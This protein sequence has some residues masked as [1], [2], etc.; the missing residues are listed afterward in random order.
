MKKNKTLKFYLP[1]FFL[2]FLLLLTTYKTTKSQDLEHYLNQQHPAKV[3]PSETV[4]C[5]FD[6]FLDKLL[7]T[8][9]KLRE[10]Q[11][12]ME[13]IY[14]QFRSNKS[15][16]EDKELE[17]KNATTL[18][19][20]YTLPIVV[21][22]IHDN[23]VENISDDQVIQ[24]IAD[25]NEAF[26]NTS[27][28]DSTI[29]VDTKI[30]FCLAMQD[31]DGNA[32]TGITRTESVLTYNVNYNSSA[33]DIALKDLSRWD[34]LKYINIW[35]VGSIAGNVAGYSTL[36]SSVGNDNDG[37]VNEAQYFGTSKSNSTIHT[38]EIGHYLGL[39]HTF[40]G[41]CTNN[42][43]LADGDKVCDTPPDQSTAA[44]P[45]NATVNSCITDED[46]PSVNNPFRPVSLGGIGDQNDL[47]KNYMDYAF[48]CGFM[49]TQGQADRMVFF[50]NNVRME[51]LGAPSCS[52]PCML[53]VAASFTTPST[54]VNQGQT[55]NFTNTTI[56]GTI[57]E[58]S[59]Y[60]TPFST[61]TN[62]SYLFTAQGIFTITL[63]A[64]NAEPGCGDSF[65]MQIEVTC[66]N[67]PC[68]EICNNSIDDDN[69]GLADCLD[70]DCDCDDLC[71][72][73]GE[74]DNWFFGSNAA[75]SF[76]GGGV[77]I[78]IANSSLTASEGVASISDPDGNLL[79]YTN[80]RTA[81]NA[82]NSL[83]S[84]GTGLSGS[85]IS[86]QSSIIVPLPESDSL[87]YI[88]TVPDWIGN[89]AGLRYTV[90]DMSLNSGLGGVIATQKNISVDLNVAERVTAALHENCRDI[91]IVS[92]QRLN[93][94]FIAY[95]LTPSGVST[96]PV[97]SSVGAVTN[98]GNRYGALKLSHDGKQIS[99]TLG[100]SQSSVTVALYD[101]DYATGVVS[102]EQI[103]ADNGLISNAYSSEFSSD[104]SK[105]YVCSYNGSFV[106][107]FDLS[108]ATWPEVLASQTN[109]AGSASGIK[110]CIQI[111]PDNKI[112]VAKNN[113][114]NMDVINFP[115][116]VGVNCG[117]SANIVNLNGN[118]ARIGLPNF[119]PFYF[120]G[121][122]SLSGVDSICLG[123]PTTFTVT[124]KDCES[125]IYSWELSGN[126][127]IIDS[128]D[129]SITVI[130]ST[131]PET[132]LI[133]VHK[134]TLC[135]IESD[136]SA[137]V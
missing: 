51:L 50:L 97:T 93:N 9:A 45:C 110:G 88:F 10:G 125:A 74:A 135:G 57:Y 38:H 102:N 134:E 67:P 103:I 68:I 71:K 100:G 106:Y 92:H 137:L 82:N 49:F 99:S 43:C 72:D 7:S 13:I 119:I 133:I 15:N 17:N 8:N 30:A 124:R 33:A 32:T 115:N 22:I 75:I 64:I 73:R 77:P 131:A 48:P 2:F 126:L 113:Q 118:N 80:G 121:P 24:A 21:H 6:T 117:Y 59:I 53:P 95:L 23:G 55:V 109:I 29:G 89:S 52:D 39:Y 98:G 28:Y 16:R 101:F 91:W 35:V 86:A 40:E 3:L 85:N 130:G 34:P 108:L 69:D 19:P 62:S 11:K 120:E 56:G 123:V 31:P 58:W 70:P 42:N 76:S 14:Q 54:T 122:L 26:E 112:Y 47:F 61:A 18:L 127:T 87:Y 60:G 44:T 105:L 111:G 116:G 114:S 107:Q 25:L 104:N 12:E 27:Y 65:E 136:S 129:Q 84:D 132:A 66:P 1:F 128:T 96:T 46:D 63:V 5:G 37:I 79:L 41:G 94:N 36:P 81:W 90:V 78:S 83:M 20:E 4:T